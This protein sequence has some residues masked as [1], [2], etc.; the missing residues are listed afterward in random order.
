MTNKKI[1]G[2]LSGIVDKMNVTYHG[3]IGLGFSPG[4]NRRVVP[5]MIDGVVA[6]WKMQCLEN[7]TWVDSDEGTFETMEDLIGYYKDGE[8]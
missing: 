8:L 5:I 6:G 1:K 4:M 2:S 3:F 7:G